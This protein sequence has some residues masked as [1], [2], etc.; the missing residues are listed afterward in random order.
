MHGIG[1]DATGPLWS[2]RIAAGDILSA[3]PAA[4]EVRVRSV[5]VHDREV[6]VA[7]AGQRVAVAL[8]GVERGDL[9][10]GDVLVEPGAYGVRYRP[11]VGPEELCPIP[12]P[13]IVHHGTS[14]TLR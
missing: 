8:P 3:E 14:A 1:T 12:P 11:D 13:V 7:E 6:D 10:R 5:Q 2:G 4:R 9:R